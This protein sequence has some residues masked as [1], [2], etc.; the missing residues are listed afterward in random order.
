MPNAAELQ[1]PIKGP[2]TQ[3]G[4]EERQG[5][6]RTGY[7]SSSPRAQIS[8]RKGSFGTGTTATLT[9]ALR[10]PGGCSLPWGC[11]PQVGRFPSRL[12]SVHETES[13]S[14][15]VSL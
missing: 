6:V 3:M 5:G 8:L 11:C 1:A 13:P 12:A 15:P 2:T 10:T 7:Q 9:K 14:L 4:G